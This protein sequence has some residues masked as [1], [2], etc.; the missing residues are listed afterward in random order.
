M[1]PTRPTMDEIYIKFA[2]LIA[3]RSTCNRYGTGCVI[4][5]LDKRRVLSLG[6]NGTPHN[7]PHDCNGAEGLCNCL[8]S[9][10]NA[11]LKLQTTEHCIMYSTHSPCLSCARYILQSNVEKLVFAEWYRDEYPIQYINTYS[12]IQV[13]RVKEDA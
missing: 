7:T 12:E 2:K 11:L 8:H 1:I 5:S 13:Y 3:T 9:E 4:T 6:Y 10:L